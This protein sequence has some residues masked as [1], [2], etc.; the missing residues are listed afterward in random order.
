M[1]VVKQLSVFMEN[2]PGMLG[3]LA[4]LLAEHKI[5]IEALTVSDTM[6]HAVLRI[7]VDDPEKALHVFGE[8]G[9]LVLETEMIALELTNRP[10]LLRDVA[11][12]L[13]KTGI[14]IDYAYGSAGVAGERGLLYLRVSDIEKAAQV[15][16]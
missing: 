2:R 11:L 5:N 16:K 13:G 10:G 4:S 14:N 8:R 6:D 7:V 12:K 3:N 9:T 1:K 15:L